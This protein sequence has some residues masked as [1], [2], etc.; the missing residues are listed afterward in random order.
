[1][2]LV[3]RD[4][5]TVFSLRDPRLGLV[6]AVSLAHSRVRSSL[7]WR[8]LV[9]TA[10]RAGTA[11]VF[12]LGILTGSRSAAAQVK[13][14]TRRAQPVKF[15]SLA[16]FR[17]QLGHPELV[18]C[19]ESIVAVDTVQRNGE[20]YRVAAIICGG[21]DT[22]VLRGRESELHLAIVDLDRQVLTAQLAGVS[23]VVVVRRN[24]FGGAMT[25][26]VPNA[27]E[28]QM[29]AWASAQRAMSD[30]IEKASAAKSEAERKQAAARERAE[31]RKRYS[32][33]GWSEATIN[34]VLNG[35][36]SIGMTDAMVRA[37]W[38]PPDR[39]NRTINVSGVSEQW[40]YGNRTY[41]YM[42]NGRVSTIQDSR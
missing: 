35:K 3:F 42:D 25:M 40:V 33:L 30:A 22:L 41:V 10:M 39:I 29:Q 13:P 5:V 15:D 6:S 11:I 2:I 7:I 32:A 14:S 17:S 20:A 28:A 38:G 21:G 4:K 36:I 1:M 37:S 16:A 27:P 18:G 23:G 31:R 8:R 34:S 9:H 26:L 12:A 24:P 19:S